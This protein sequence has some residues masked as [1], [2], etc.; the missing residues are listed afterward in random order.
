YAGA[1]GVLQSGTD[2]PSVS[3]WAPREL[4]PDRG[5]GVRDRRGLAELKRRRP[6]AVPAAWPL[7]ERLNPALEAAELSATP[8]R[9]SWQLDDVDVGRVIPAPRRAVWLRRA[10]GRCRCSS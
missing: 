8:S 1:S 5:F 10:P 3:H 7:K 2:L 9:G 6:T 4:D